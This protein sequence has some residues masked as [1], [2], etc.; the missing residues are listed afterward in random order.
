MKNGYAEKYIRTE[1]AEWYNQYL[2]N[3]DLGT[4][5]IRVY[6][7]VLCLIIL[8]SFFHREFVFWIYIY[9]YMTW[10]AMKVYKLTMHHTEKV[11]NWLYFWF[12]L[13]SGLYSIIVKTSKSPREPLKKSW[14]LLALKKSGEN[15]PVCLQLESLMVLF[16]EVLSINSCVGGGSS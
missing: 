3:C 7:Y 4:T 13:C 10:W 5:W 9:V 6:F 8:D 1:H 15:E 12:L 14:V 16:F 2:I 11:E